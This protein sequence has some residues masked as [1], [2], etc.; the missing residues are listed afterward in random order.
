MPK[1]KVLLVGL[2]VA[3]IFLN[4]P[5]QYGADTYRNFL[6]GGQVSHRKQILPQRGQDARGQAAV[7]W[8][9]LSPC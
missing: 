8:P 9:E 7:L 4:L 1:R 6:M 5:A 3:L 2:V